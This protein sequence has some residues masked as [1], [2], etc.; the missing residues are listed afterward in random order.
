[1]CEMQCIDQTSIGLGP[2]FFLLDLLRVRSASALLYGC[3][4]SLLVKL[5][6]GGL[7]GSLGYALHVSYQSRNASGLA[8]FVDP[9]G[10]PVI[11]CLQSALHA[12]DFDSTGPSCIQLASWASLRFSLLQL[13]QK[14][15]VVGGF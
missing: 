4:Q 13:G 15:R 2:L 11:T 7:W 6:W 14:W 8:T 12:C 5:E 9:S 1:M 10:S 3:V